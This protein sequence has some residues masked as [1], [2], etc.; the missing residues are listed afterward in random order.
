MVPP[1][2]VLCVFICVV[3]SRRGLALTAAAARVLQRL[4]FGP[5]G[6]PETICS[7]LIFVIVSTKLDL[8]RRI[9]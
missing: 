2:L 9:E 3:L 6:P 7:T 8:H 4:E 5:S 1:V